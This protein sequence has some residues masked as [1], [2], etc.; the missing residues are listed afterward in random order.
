MLTQVVLFL[1]LFAYSFVVSQSFSYIISL[2]N[3]LGRLDANSYILMRKLIDEN[4]RAKFK[5]VFY[6]TWIFVPVL[7]IVS[8]VEKDFF[9]FT[10][11]LI[12]LAGYLADTIF[13]LKGNMP[14]NNTINSWNNESYPSDWDRYRQL[15]FRAFTKRQVSNTIGFISLLVAAVFQ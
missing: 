8:A 4:F 2:R 11:A 14:I 13:M 6:S 7:C 1:A 15:W 12:S 3:V 9:V 10:C 5:Y